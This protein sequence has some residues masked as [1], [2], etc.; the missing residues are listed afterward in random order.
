M[1]PVRKITDVTKEKLD[2]GTGGS[3]ATSDSQTAMVARQQ[4]WTC[5]PTDHLDTSGATTSALGT[6]LFST[7]SPAFMPRLSF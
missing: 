1:R 7:S 4:C 6:A 2:R 5:I 3:E